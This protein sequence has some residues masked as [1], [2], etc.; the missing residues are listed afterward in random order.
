MQTVSD[1]DR[2]LWLSRYLDGELDED[3]RATVA[4]KIRTDETWRADFEELQHDDR[5]VA[6]SARRYRADDGFSA[7]VVGKVRAG[8][9]VRDAHAAKAPHRPVRRHRAAH[10]HWLLRVA[11]LVALVVGGAV[12][13]KSYLGA[14]PPRTAALPAAAP[15]DEPTET[16]VAEDLRAIAWA[17]GTRILARKGTVLQSL[18]PRALKLDGAAFLHVARDLAAPFTVQTAGATIEVLGT[19]FDVKTS[20]DGVR[21]RVAEGHVRA[22]SATGKT[23]E[24]FAGTEIL[25]DLRVQ[26]FDVRELSAAWKHPD[27]EALAAPWPQLGG[28]PGHTNITPLAG[29]ANL[30][31]KPELFYR[32]PEGAGAPQSGAVVSTH[33][34]VLLVLPFGPDG[35]RL[36]E[37]AGGG[38]GR[39]E[40]RTVAS[41]VAADVSPVITP[42][43]LVV[44]LGADGTVRAFGPAREAWVHKEDGEAGALAVACDGAVLLSAA[45]GLVA[46]DGS[47]GTVLWRCSIPGGVRQPAAVLPGGIIRVVSAGGSVYLVDQQGHLADGRTAVAG[48]VEAPPG[49][50]R[51]GTGATYEV[52]GR[53][54]A[55]LRQETARQG[56]PQNRPVGFSTLADGDVVRHGLAIAPGKLIVTTTRG[57]QVFE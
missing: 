2:E 44:A 18:G 47:S 51:D 11:A 22:R 25:P 43:G 56:A 5:L 55:H 41:G 49:C 14:P 7:H 19:S 31:A 13:W 35:A 38:N 40:W 28:S 57:I 45:S 26:P 48:P 32:Y 4:E 20:S 15:K 34:R 36:M 23:A 3:A 33:G 6:F 53:G 52:S 10:T 54:V 21:V 39:G 12:A 50:V 8:A 30:V 27:T 16:V 37:L 46:L 1:S 42:H 29:P 24:A 9:H 17:D